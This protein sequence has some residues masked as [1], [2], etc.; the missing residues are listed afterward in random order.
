MA[1]I[2]LRDV[3][4]QYGAHPT[5]DGVDLTLERGER[6]G[7]LGRN[8]AGKTTLL[9]ILSGDLAPEAGSVER[10]DGL[11]LSRLIQEIPDRAGGSVWDFVALDFGNR[12]VDAARLRRGEAP[13]G[14]AD[15]AWQVAPLVDTAVARLGLDPDAS[16]DTLSGGLKRRAALARALASDPDILLL[17]EPTNHLDI[18]AIEQLEELLLR[19][20]QRCILFVT[21]DRAFLQRVATRIVELDR[22]RLSSWPCDYRTYVERREAQLVAEAAEAARLDKRIAAEEVWAGRNVEARRTKSVGRLRELD[23]LRKQRQE[24]RAQPGTLRMAI[25]EAER[26]GRLVC[27][28]R[29]LT[30]A[31]G[32][33]TVVRGLS[34]F[35]MRG[36]RIGI[37]GPNGCGKTTLVRLLLGELAPMSGEVRTGA[38][39][40]VVYFD[41]QRELLDPDRT[42]AETVADGSDRVTVN[43]RQRHVNGYLQDFLF[44]ADRARVPVRVLSGGE[45]ARLLLARLFLKPSNVLVL[46]EPTNDLD[47]DTLDLLEDQIAAYPGTVLLV[48]HDRAFLND[49]VTS[50][51]AFEGDGVVGDYPGG[52]DDWVRQRPRP[53]AR[54]EERRRE[55]VEPVPA[56]TA[57]RKLSFKERRELDELPA[58]IEQ[59]EAEQASVSARLS[60]PSTYASPSGLARELTARHDELAGLLETAYRRWSELESRA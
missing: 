4:I 58:R 27:E 37:I 8:G 32:D 41:Q 16:F 21:H 52:Y 36:D 18:A 7:L 3:H 13:T 42:V 34:T 44:T 38:N 45:R 35:I 15:A 28:T 60:E 10:L 48:S 19:E 53:A 49:V 24:R 17:D 47:T 20:T 5:L 59:L 26:S 2:T 43:G 57:A 55:A 14:D 51:L 50:T 33:Q 54:P 6:I 30:Y 23:R 22:G 25:Q 1:L 11:R 40:E 39:L 31:W 12:G 46:D 56:P 9:R 29:D